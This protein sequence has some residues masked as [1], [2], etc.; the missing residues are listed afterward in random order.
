MN[1]NVLKMQN[2]RFNIEY[3]GLCFLI[4]SFCFSSIYIVDYFVLL[5]IL[6][7]WFLFARFRKPTQNIWYAHCNFCATE[8][9]ANRATKYPKYKYTARRYT[10][11]SHITRENS[12]G[13][14]YTEHRILKSWA[15]THTAQHITLATDNYGEH[16]YHT[17]HSQNSKKKHTLSTHTSL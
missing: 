7:F 8:S 4:L 6:W 14:W 3:S 5:H 17:R 2:V 1:R 15:L 13:H 10:H 12:K 11:G 9:M 16:Y